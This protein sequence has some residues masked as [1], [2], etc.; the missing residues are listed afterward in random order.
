MKINRIQLRTMIKKVLNE[1]SSRE[2]T[3]EL[4]CSKGHTHEYRVV[5][6]TE[7]TSCKSCKETI[8]VAMYQLD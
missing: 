7:T 4:T 3:V 2:K 8:D 5:P 6:E 1:S